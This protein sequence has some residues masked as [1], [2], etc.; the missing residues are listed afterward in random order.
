MNRFAALSIAALAFCGSAWGQAIGTAANVQ[1]L[2]TVSDGQTLSNLQ[3]GQPIPNGSTIITGSGGSATLQLQVQGGACSVSIP[4]GS[5]LQ[6]SSAQTCSQLNASV[7]ASTAA[8]ESF[9]A[10]N[11]SGVVAAATGLLEVGLVTR[12]KLSGE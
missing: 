9:F 12:T 5:Q 11:G 3:P 10:A 6:V 7:V 2:V 4:A 1:G 8:P